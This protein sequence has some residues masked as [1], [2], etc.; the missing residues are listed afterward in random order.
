MAMNYI[1]ITLYPREGESEYDYYYI[2]KTHD[3]HEYE[4]MADHI[5]FISNN[6]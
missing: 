4:A 3:R 5:R 6:E 2:I 1:K